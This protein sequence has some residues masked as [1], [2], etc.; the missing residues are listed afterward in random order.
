[1]AALA[2]NKSPVEIGGAHRDLPVE[3]GAHIFVGSLVMIGPA[4]S[5]AR[6]AAAGSQTPVAAGVA[7]EEVDNTGGADGA[8]MVRT[9]SGVFLFANDGSNAVTRA[10]IG[11][12]CY[13]VDDQTVSSLDTSRITAGT[14][15][16]VTS[17]GVWVRV[18]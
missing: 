18:D 11:E 7:M 15:F 8:Q 16:D 13:A 12:P 9:R 17:E 1:M 4:G 14:V 6:P 2:D 10:H 3:A 5:E